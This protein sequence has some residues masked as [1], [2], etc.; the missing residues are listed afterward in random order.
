[1]SAYV[2]LNLV[3]ES[4]KRDKMTGL[5]SILSLFRNKLNTLNNT[6]TRMFDY[7]YH[8]ALRLF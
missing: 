1:M 5:Q 8:M 3:N 4:R 7:I 6:G 2:L